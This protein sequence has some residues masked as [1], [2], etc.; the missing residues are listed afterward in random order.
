VPRV[1]CVLV[2]VDRCVQHDGPPLL[3]RGP[4]VPQRSGQS[5]MTST[6]WDLTATSQESRWTSSAIQRIPPPLDHKQVEP[7]R[8]TR[9]LRIRA[10]STSGQ[11]QGRPTTNRGL[12][13]HSVI[14]RP[15]QPAC[16]LKPLVPERAPT[17]TRY[18]DTDRGPSPQS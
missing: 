13:A 4:I 7:R 11:S 5:P 16:S 18:P 8:A 9:Q 10:R 17:L 3:D 2:D 1:E 15:A 6:S 12:A 14:R